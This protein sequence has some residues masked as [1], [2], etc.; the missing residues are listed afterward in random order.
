MVRRPQRRLR[1][2]FTLLETSWVWT[3]LGG[4]G[5]R[6]DQLTCLSSHLEFRSGLC[7]PRGYEEAVGGEETGQTGGYFVRAARAKGVRE[8]KRSSRKG[9]IGFQKL[10]YSKGLR[11]GPGA[12]CRR[13][14]VIKSSQVSSEGPI[15]VCCKD[16][17]NLP[18]DSHYTDRKAVTSPRST[19]PE[20]AACGANYRPQSLLLPFSSLL[21]LSFLP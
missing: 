11:Q 18:P 15:V 4:T 3:L 13:H 19:D 1:L 14:F 12:H 6:S 7:H 8:K 21:L 16:T 9:A 2:L 20:R 5:K 10:P 17:Y